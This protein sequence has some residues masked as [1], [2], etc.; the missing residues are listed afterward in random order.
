MLNWLFLLLSIVLLGIGPLL[1]EW[2]RRGHSAILAV[3]DGFALIGVGSLVLFHVLPGSYT[4]L[5]VWAFGFATVGLIAPYLLERYSHKAVKT[6]HEVL[7]TCVLV[8]IGLHATFDGMLLSSRGEMD[9]AQLATALAVILHRIPAGLALWWLLRPT[10][11]IRWAMSALA[12]TALGTVLGFGFGGQVQDSA[13][14][15]FQALVAGA[16]LHIVLD[17]PHAPASSFDRPGWRLAECIG[18]LLG[19]GVTLFLP[20]SHGHPPI[21]FGQF[22]RDFLHLAMETAPALLLG[23]LLSGALA[24]FAPNWSIAWLK[25]GGTF[26]QA[27]RGTAYGLPLPICSC[28]VVP[29]YRGLVAKG[30]PA[31]AAMAFLVATPELGIESMFI[32]LPLLGSKM[33]IARLA[34]ALIAALVVGWL[35]G[36]VVPP[37]SDEEQSTT[38][39]DG[40]HE[41]LSARVIRVFRVGLVDV[42]ADTSAWIVAGLAIA[43]ALKPMDLDWLGGLSP[44]VDVL[45]L[46]LVGMPF[47]VCATGATPLAAI[48]IFKGV[49]P[50]A[51]LAFLLVGPATNVT[52]FGILSGLHGRR[53]A[54]VFAL[55]MIGLAV[56]MGLVVNLVVD[57]DISELPIA[58]EHPTTNW[59][60]ATAGTVLLVALA[61]CLLKSGPRSFMAGLFGNSPGAPGDHDHG[62][63]CCSHGDEPPE[64]DAPEVFQIGNIPNDKR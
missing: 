42:F 15:I 5:G 41:S 18:A 48:F 31:A 34:C 37:Y 64:A 9:S 36:R 22:G 4:H 2:A 24:V 12:V 35:V 47:Y 63:S 8:G 16:L 11:G 62:G 26:S 33:T 1:T 27:L 23:Y 38:K 3:L 44:G 6:S 58:H 60:G 45:V 56:G 50:G 51:A 52:T 19:I 14:A 55:T 10:L 21:D 25:R 17:R 54:I 39:S 30:V 7:A 13:I 46:A 43:A 40:E 29:V 59:L 49:S 57:V 53:V 20:N 28:G 61:L 32:S